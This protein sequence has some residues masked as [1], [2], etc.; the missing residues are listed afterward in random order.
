MNV[1]SDPACTD[2]RG[3]ANRT[4]FGEQ[5]QTR[6]LIEHDKRLNHSKRV[7]R[8]SC[9][10]A[11]Q[12]LETVGIPRRSDTEQALRLLRAALGR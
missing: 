1:Q 6:P 2:F 12:S 7:E 8:A 3:L 10:A 4:V 5:L 11:Q 9:D